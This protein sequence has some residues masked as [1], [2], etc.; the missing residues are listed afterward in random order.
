VISND[1]KQEVLSRISEIENFI[2]THDGK[3]ITISTLGKAEAAKAALLRQS[4]DSLAPVLRTALVINAR[5]SAMKSRYERF[6]QEFPKISTLSDLKRVMDSTEP[7][8]FCKTYLNINAKIVRNPKYRL[9]KVLTDGFLKYQ[10]ENDWPTEIETIRKWSAKVNLDELEK[11][12]IGSLH[13]VGPG[14]VGNIKLC[15]G[16]PVVKRD[17]NVIW[18][19]TEILQADVPSDFK[20]FVAFME[21]FARSV[22]IQ[23]LRYLDSILF[24]YGKAKKNISCKTDA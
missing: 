13:G 16:E 17:R 2:T 5:E 21:E 12:P 8:E 10:Q 3:A 11:D 15:L 22:G 18:V 23:D 7:L 1:K 20:K 24:E 19:M 9:L 6:I 4:S 14:V